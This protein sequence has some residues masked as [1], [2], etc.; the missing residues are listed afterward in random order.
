LQA[1]GG[2]PFPNLSPGAYA[3]YSS[4]TVAHADALQSGNNRLADVEVA[5]SGGAFTSSPLGII[6]NEMSRVVA[7]TFQTTPNAYGRGS[8]LEVGLAVTPSGENQIVL[9]T[10]VEALASVTTDLITEEVGPLALDPLALA[11]LLRGQAQGKLVSNP[12]LT[13]GDLAYGLGYAADVGLLDTVPGGSFDAPLVSTTAANPDRAVSQSVS[14]TALRGTVAPFGLT[15]ETRQTIAPVT[16]FKGTPNQFTIE[17]LG[18][19]VLSVTANGTAGSASVHYGPAAASPE[20]PVLRVINAANVVT[21]VLTLQQLLTNNGLTVTVPG[22]V[23][24]I[25]IGEPPRALGGA[26]GSPPETSPTTGTL[27]SAAVDVARVRLLLQG[28]DHL[29][30]IRIGH[31]EAA[32]AVPSGGI[33]CPPT[34]NE[35]PAPT[36]EPEVL[37]A[38]EGVAVR[39]AGALPKTGGTAG[40][41]LPLAFLAL[42]GLLGGL[43]RRSARS[44]L[45][46]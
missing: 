3:G 1:V 37:G 10:K 5:F 33:T 12:C 41:L 6:H 15:S 38:V 7:P 21:N 27:A 26:G 9:P 42:S 31:M 4:G 19:W 36:R 46:W 17:A 30:D 23:A 25:A 35:P 2:N 45:D 32:V 22:G 24:E 39:P 29:A 13:S 18:E 8:G 28:Q 16:L 11:R 43:S 44:P 14:R 20:T 40:P 34:T